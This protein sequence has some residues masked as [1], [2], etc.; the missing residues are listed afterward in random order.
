[1]VPTPGNS[2]KLFSGLV[3]VLSLVL[4]SNLSVGQNHSWREIQG[5]PL[6][7]FDWNC[8]SPSTYPQ[9]KLAR[10]MK[11]VLKREQIADGPPD[12]AFA[13]DLNLDGKPEYFVP[14]D[15]GAVGNCNWGVFA[16]SP[17]RFLGKVNG[18]YIFVHQREGGWP[19]IVTYGHL[20]AMEGALVT[21]V[22][23]RERYRMSGKELPIGPEDRTLEIQNVRGH[24]MPRFLDHARGA[25]KDL[26][27]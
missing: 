3:A 13:F 11:E 15:C 12:R 16:V 1:M 5:R 21:Y 22:F 14:L 23:T 17:T 6:T 24:K 27:S 20:S 19:V 2:K 9:L 8:A 18:Q 26:G 25:C 10:V 7:K 4:V